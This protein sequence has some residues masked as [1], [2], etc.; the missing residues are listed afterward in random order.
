MGLYRRGGALHNLGD[1][2]SPSGPSS[3]PAYPCGLA[4][5]ELCKTLGFPRS[6]GKC[7]KDKGGSR[8]THLREPSVSPVGKGGEGEGGWWF[9][10]GCT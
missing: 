4:G 3:P 2:L 5:R 7:P 9:R 6:R 8:D 10:R 1:W